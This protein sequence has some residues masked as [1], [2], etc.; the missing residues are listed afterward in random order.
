M[1]EKPIS[2]WEWGCSTF[3]GL[4]WENSHGEANVPSAM[5]IHELN[6]KGTWQITQ[7]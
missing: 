6:S 5:L 4:W 7:E 3:V 2:L 1:S